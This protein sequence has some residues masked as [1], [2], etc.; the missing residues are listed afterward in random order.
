M[1]FLDKSFKILV[2]AILF[3]TF[4]YVFVRALVIGIVHDEAFT[5]LLVVRGFLVHSGN[6]HLLNSFFVLI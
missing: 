5:F 2:I 1:V 6:N 3:L 4:I